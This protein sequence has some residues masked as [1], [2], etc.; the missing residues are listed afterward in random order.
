MEKDAFHLRPGTRQGSSLSLTSV[1]SIL[2]F[3][4]NTINKEKELR[5]MN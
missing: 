1:S 4:A 5:G 3:L 2:D